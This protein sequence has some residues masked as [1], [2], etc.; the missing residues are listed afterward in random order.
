V[1]TVVDVA[2]KGNLHR[3][4]TIGP[5]PGIDAQQAN[6][7]LN[8]QHRAD[9]QHDRHRDFDDDQE[10]ARAVRALRTNRSACS[11]SQGVA[12][13]C[14]SGLERRYQAERDAR[15][16]RDDQREPD[17]SQVQRRIGGARQADRRE[18]RERVQGK[19]GDG[20]AYHA[21]RERD[22][23]AFDQ[24]LTQEALAIRAERSAD[25][26]LTL[27]GGRAH[28]Q[29]VRDV[30]TRYQ[31]N[32]AYGGQ[33]HEQW[34]PHARDQLFPQRDHPNGP[35]A[36]RLRKTPGDIG[37]YRAK[38]GFS[39]RQAGVV[40]QA[41]H[42]REALG[43][44]ASPLR[45]AQDVQG[46]DVGLSRESQGCGQIGRTRE[47]EPLRKHA[48]D[49]GR[50]AVDRDGPIYHGRILTETSLPQTVTN[51]HQTR[52]WEIVWTKPTPDHR[53]HAERFE[54]VR[55]D[56]HARKTLR[57]SRSGDVDAFGPDRRESLEG[58]VSRAVVG[59]V[60]RR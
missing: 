25:R 3:E 13:I 37:G 16:A 29:Q 43:R 55:A 7:R 35:T 2:R 59:H 39:R 52:R 53:L 46:P 9:E 1:L 14:T 41:P 17:D 50:L 60:T 57:L 45:R 8:E 4:Q 48:D 38:V 54:E 6:E 18:D 33:E 49:R 44:A 30:G 28:Q 15:H 22:D 27:P 51:Q 23:E 26:H 34:R 10:I 31:E 24:Q 40:A 36:V 58:P 56:T 11:L 5:E 21:G 19:P 42:E 12:N 47:P 20:Q 32:E